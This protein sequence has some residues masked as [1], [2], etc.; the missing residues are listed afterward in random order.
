ML[1]MQVNNLDLIEGKTLKDQP[2]QEIPS[3]FAELNPQQQVSG[4]Y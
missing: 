3:I 1:S 4:I 2:V